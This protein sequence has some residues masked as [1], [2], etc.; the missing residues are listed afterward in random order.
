MD[1][2]V[3]NIKNYEDT[4][5]I[6]IGRPSKYG[7]P[8]SSKESRITDNIVGS[9]EEALDKFRDYINN[10][11]EIINELIEELKNNGVYKLGCWC[12]PS[13]CHGDILVEK[14]NEKKFKSI[15]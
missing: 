15:L 1:I 10:K 6:Y 2:K 7:N 12:V 3:V 13:K 14:I 4:D 11:P 8:F 9:K 5:Y